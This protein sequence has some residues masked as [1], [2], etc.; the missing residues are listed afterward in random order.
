LVS[1]IYRTWRRHVNPSQTAFRQPRELKASRDADRCRKT[2]GR[3]RVTLAVLSDR[4]ERKL[5]LGAWQ[6]EVAP[7]AAMIR[8]QSLDLE[9]PR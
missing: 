1:F 8:R 3:F 7:V 9:W 6:A 5:K 2:G 4:C